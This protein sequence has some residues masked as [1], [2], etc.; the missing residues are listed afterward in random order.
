MFRA[1]GERRPAVVQQIS[2]GGCLVDLDEGLY[3]GDEFR[4]ELELPNKNRLPLT[5]KVVYCFDNAG[6]GAKFL[7]IT[8]FEQAL[9]AKTISSRLD[10]DGLPLP[11]DAFEKPPKFDDAEMILK[12]SSEKEKRE[13]K[14][15]EVMVLDSD[16]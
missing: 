12:I 9:I 1:S 3:P 13:E 6:I 5:C 15:E 7:D 10:L 11:I 2:V 14:L 4:L 16:H 8:K